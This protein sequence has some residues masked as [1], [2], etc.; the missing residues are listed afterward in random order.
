MFLVV[1]QV[2]AGVGSREEEDVPDPPVLLPSSAAAHE[3]TR[4]QWRWSNVPPLFHHCSRGFELYV[5]A[6]LWY[7]ID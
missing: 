7:G 3:P 6:W 5:A 4:R 1:L 2:T